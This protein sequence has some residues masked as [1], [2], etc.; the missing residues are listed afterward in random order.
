MKKHVQYLE[1]TRGEDI[2]LDYVRLKDGREVDFAIENNGTISTLIEAKLS[3]TELS[4]SLAL[5][6]EKFKNAGA[7]QIVQNAKTEKQIKNVHIVP[8][9]N[10]L[11]NLSA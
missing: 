7:Y 10:W 11:A 2:Q 3:D 9:A 1:D 4:T 5:F 8:A 6:S